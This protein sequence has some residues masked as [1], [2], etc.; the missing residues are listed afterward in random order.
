MQQKEY[1]KQV[2]INCPFDEEYSAIFK[3]IIF[4]LFDCGFVPRCSLEFDDASQVRI[5]KIGSLIAES[6]YGIHDIS[7]TQP[8]E[9]TGLPR[10]NMPLELGLFLGA[11]RYGTG[12]QK[13]KVCLIFDKEKY[14]YQSFI[15]DISGQ[16]IR[17][18]SNDPKVAIKYLRDWLSHL[19]GPRK[20]PGG[21]EINRRFQIFLKAL[22]DMS[23]EHKWD[24]HDLTYAEYINLISI[25]SADNELGTI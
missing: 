25:W 3:A 19:S 20:I 7:R 8:D 2:F 13:N 5:E 17:S 16:D 24:A 10:F 6:M 4:T 18:H 9:K 12:R 11:K 14:R 1:E 22:G 23:K 15:S 21:G